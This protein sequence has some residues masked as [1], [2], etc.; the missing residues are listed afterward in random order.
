MLSLFKPV[1]TIIIVKCTQRWTGLYKLDSYLTKS[2]VQIIFWWRTDWHIDHLIID[3]KM[4]L[5]GSGKLSSNKWDEVTASRTQSSCWWDLW[6]YSFC[7]ENNPPPISS[8]CVSPPSIL[9]RKS[10][11]SVRTPRGDRSLGEAVKFCAVSGWRQKRKWVLVNDV[12]HAGDLAHPRL[13]WGSPPLP[14]SLGV[15]DLS[16]CNFALKIL[17]FLKYQM[18]PNHRFLVLKSIPKKE[19]KKIPAFF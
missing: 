8:V 12:Q 6:L 18:L 10:I 15:E 3:S 13:V 1:F 2:E 19:R 5:I 4:W 17:P 16:S 7:V 14:P 11:G 9:R